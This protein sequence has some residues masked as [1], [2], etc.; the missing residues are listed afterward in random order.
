MPKISVVIPVKNCSDT[1]EKSISSVLN[2]TFKDFEIVVVNNNCT[3]NTIEKISNFGD[4][5]IKI[6]DCKIPGIVPALNTGIYNSD[7]FMIARQDGDD[8]W[9]PNKLEKQL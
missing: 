9:Y 7:S 5:K 8:V 3:D 1:I 4:K 2:Q 6:I